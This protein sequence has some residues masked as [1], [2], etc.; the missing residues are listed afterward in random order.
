[1]LAGS[2]GEGG[3]GN[4]DRH[5]VHGLLI[6]GRDTGVVGDDRST[7]GTPL[8]CSGGDDGSEGG[9]GGG[10]KRS[11]SVLWVFM[12]GARHVHVVR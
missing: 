4:G 10:K 6:C 7:V 9:A 8:N 11:S 2:D 5:C 3:D 12:R 1:M